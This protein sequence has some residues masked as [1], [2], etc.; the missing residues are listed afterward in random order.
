MT[1]ALETE[2]D[3]LLTY[4]GP[5]LLRAMLAPPPVPRELRPTTPP[6]RRPQ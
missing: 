3:V 4:L 5:E 6:P 2:D 1:K